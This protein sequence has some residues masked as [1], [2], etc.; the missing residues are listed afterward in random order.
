MELTLTFATPGRK[1]KVAVTQGEPGLDLLEDIRANIPAL[2]K[3]SMEQM[4][5]TCPVFFNYYK[6]KNINEATASSWPTFRGKQHAIVFIP[7]GFLGQYLRFNYSIKIAG[8]YL[9]WSS[10]LWTKLTGK[11]WKKNI[12]NIT[13]DF[14]LSDLLADWEKA[15]CPTY[16]GITEAEYLKRVKDEFVAF[17]KDNKWLTLFL[18]NFKCDYQIELMIQKL[19]KLKLIWRGKDGCYYRNEEEY[20]SRPA[21][22]KR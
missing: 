22:T 15:G 4:N 9:D 7:E 21:I 14:V 10:K 2:K 12:V 16:W 11:L 6:I 17:N 19:L 8:S 18:E 13:S 1:E 3:V 20:R 5:I